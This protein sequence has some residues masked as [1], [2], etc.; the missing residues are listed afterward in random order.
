M[1]NTL[2]HLIRWICRKCFVLA[3]AAMV[4]T[5]MLITT[6]FFEPRELTF[7]SSRYSFRVKIGTGGFILLQKQIF[8]QGSCYKSL[9][10]CLKHQGIHQLLFLLMLLLSQKYIFDWHAQHIMKDQEMG[11]SKYNEKHKLYIHPIDGM[12]LLPQP[13]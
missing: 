13:L 11:R 3:A 8:F 6:L 4:T 5:T 7:R 12:F 1:S 9:F 2:L 10:Q